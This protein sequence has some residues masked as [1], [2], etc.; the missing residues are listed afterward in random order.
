M[1]S[2]QENTKC[3]GTGNSGVNCVEEDVISATGTSTTVMTTVTRSYVAAT[4][5]VFTITG[6]QS[7]PTVG[8]QAS[9]T[10]TRKSAASHIMVSFTS[11]SIFGFIGVAYVLFS[12]IF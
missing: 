1:G 11:A 9:P 7:V 2:V 3:T 5:P 10:T 12:S 6:T 8:T 4:S